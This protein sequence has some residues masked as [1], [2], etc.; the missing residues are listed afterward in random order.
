MSLPRP[1]LTIF[2]LF[3]SLVCFGQE[4]SS[5]SNQISLD[6]TKKI[7]A[8]TISAPTIHWLNPTVDTVTLKDGKLLIQ[9]SVTSKSRL[10]NLDISLLTIQGE[11]EKFVRKLESGVS[12]VKSNLVEVNNTF[13]LDNGINVIEVVAENRDGIKSKSRRFAYV[14]V[15]KTEPKGLEKQKIAASI[16]SGPI[17]LLTENP[18]Y[19]QYQ[20]RPLILVGSSEHYGAVV[21]KGFDFKKYLE[22]IS[23]E[24]LN[25]V[26][27]YGGSYIEKVGDFSIQRNTLAPTP[28]N[29]V[30]PWKRSD[31]TGYILG[32]NKFDLNTWDD[33]Y[34]A[35]LK[36][37]LAFAKEKNVIVEFTLFSSYYGSGWK[38][39]PLNHTN[40]INK[41]DNIPNVLVNTLD[42]GNIIKDQEKYVRK[43]VKEL[44]SFD[45]LYFEIQNEPWADQID[46]IFVTNEYDQD[47]K[48]TS[49]IQV[50]SNRSKEWRSQVVK[51]IRDEEKSLAN[52]HLISEEI[53]NFSYP[54]SD[55][56]PAI[57][58]FNFHYAN[59]Q[60]VQL[61]HYLNKPIGNNETG[62]AGK[63][64]RTYRRQAWR[65]LMEGGSIFNQL[66]FSFSVGKE[67]G[68]DS[69]YKS[70][71]GGSISLRRQLGIL[72]SL[73]ERFDLAH[74]H[75]DKS[76]IVAAPAYHSQAIGNGKDSWLIY[77]EA[78][79]TKAHSLGLNLQTGK[80]YEVEWLDVQKGTVL[81]KGQFDGK[82]LKV[83]V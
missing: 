52:K 75:P 44:N 34:F 70:P 29:L 15:S 66:D 50:V 19:F 26:R 25:Y 72:K 5:K 37:F 35:R 55:P 79:S 77:L 74:L 10:R 60:S 49:S 23:K 17:S 41:T 48:W 32:G 51:W 67:N 53:S 28:A 76:I 36:D 1:T 13:Q 39:S 22:T 62:F 3:I 80:D 65:F 7:N 38:Q 71:G 11:T 83:P 33:N 18:H 56:D 20:K 73:F 31:S 4:I 47:K 21:N 68:T 27:V 78:M 43:I 14:N 2:F 64:D 59:R 46:T 30:L 12:D 6:A 24:G 8:D 58:I 16:S 42:N 45:N 63:G 69:T 9:L 57:D 82:T 61:N 54:I 81:E 40:N